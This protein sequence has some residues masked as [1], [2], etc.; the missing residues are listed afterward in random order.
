ME[1]DHIL[2][3]KRNHVPKAE[4]A[5]IFSRLCLAS[6]DGK[7]PHGLLKTTAIAADVDIKVIYRIW[8]NGKATLKD[9]EQPTFANKYKGGSNKIPSAQ[10]LERVKAI[11]P[12]KRRSLKTLSVHSG[13]SFA[14]LSRMKADG[15]LKGRTSSVRPKLSDN[16]KVARMQH[17][18]ALVGSN[19]DFSAMYDQVH[20]DEKWFDLVEKNKKVYLVP[21]ELVT[22]RTVQHKSHIVR[23]MFLCAVAR[24]RLGFDGKVHLL[25][26][27][28]MAS[29]LLLSR[30]GSG[31][32]STTCRPRRSPL[33]AQRAPLK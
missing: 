11:A 20:L 22:H 3:P 32:S 19:G 21:G 14:T 25:L 9:G 16:H 30:S 27:L 1:L 13:I 6:R 26:R 24:P 23:V 17:A 5:A 29:H 31:P 2:A 28:W 12:S 8:H 15:L 18:R 33:G 7:L 10:L 4:K